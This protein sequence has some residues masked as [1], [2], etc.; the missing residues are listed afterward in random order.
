MIGRTN[1]GGGGN[2]SP[3]LYNM[4]KQN[5]AWGSD[6][7]L[8][9]ST[10]VAEYPSVILLDDGSIEI[11]LVRSTSAK[12]LSG[13]Y[14]LLKDF[15]LTNVKELVFEGF[16]TSSS[17]QTT[18]PR[19]YLAVMDRAKSYWGTNAIAK[20]AIGNT[21]EQTVTLDVSSISGFYEVFIG[22]LSTSDD[23]TS[24]TMKKLKAVR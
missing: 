6:K 18:Y 15:D 19:A 14:H 10:Y 22:L 24:V 2:A 7:K 16:K 20:I 8:Y 4:G 12:G 21:T 5:Y 17:G 9:H 11:S 13:T 1:T 3:Y 23:A